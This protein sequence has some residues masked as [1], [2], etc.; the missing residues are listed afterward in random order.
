MRK[1]L[2]WCKVSVHG[3]L[4][5]WWHSAS[6]RNLVAEEAYSPHGYQK[7]EWGQGEGLPIV[8]QA[9]DQRFNICA[10][11]GHSRPKL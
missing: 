3:P 4:D 9:G 7:G 2:F 1:G 6:W 10:L 5:L 8:P 11:G